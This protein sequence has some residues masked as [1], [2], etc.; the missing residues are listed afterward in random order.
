ML[1]HRFDQPSLI[2]RIFQF[3][4]I[5]PIGTALAISGL[6]RLTYFFAF[7]QFIGLSGDEHFYYGG[8]NN[9][10]NF[11]GLAQCG[12][13]TTEEIVSAIVASGWFMPG[14]SIVLAPVRLIS[15]TLAT[16][17]LYVGALNFGILILTA[18]LVG[19]RFGTK[20]GV[21]TAILGGVFPAM[22]VFSFMFWWELMAGQ[23]LAIM[24]LLLLNLTDQLASSNRGL[25]VRRVAMIGVLFVAVI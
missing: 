10:L 22:V 5:A 3:I 9:I 7:G 18:L 25:P 24:L 19:R 21:V 2:D 13:R 4:R 17:R 11:F 8:A 14:G 1:M 6:V 20:S 12:M 15:A 16:A 23:L